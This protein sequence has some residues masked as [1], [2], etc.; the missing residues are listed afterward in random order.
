MCVCGCTLGSGSLR[1]NC[2]P[3]PP[4]E[5]SLYKPGGLGWLSIPQRHS[6]H[7]SAIDS[8]LYRP[9]TAVLAASATVRMLSVREGC[10]AIDLGT[11]YATRT[12]RLSV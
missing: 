3:A 5:A 6:R 10:T 1:F 12:R 11:H 9:A 8:T 7:L 2:G 4:L